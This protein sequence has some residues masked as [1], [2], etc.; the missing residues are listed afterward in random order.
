MPMN[1]TEILCFKSYSEIVPYNFSKPSRPNDPCMGSAVSSLNMSNDPQTSDKWFVDVWR[2][3][4]HSY[5]M[6]CGDFGLMQGP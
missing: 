1:T 3:F 2:N 6:Y 5:C 4:F